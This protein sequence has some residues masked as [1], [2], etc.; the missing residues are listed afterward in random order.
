MRKKITIFLL[1]LF[2]VGCKESVNKLIVPEIDFPEVTSWHDAEFTGNLIVRGK[3][4]VGGTIYCDN[5]K[6]L[7][8]IE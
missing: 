5:I 8:E 2:I 7:E 1:L 3:L 4:T 6:K